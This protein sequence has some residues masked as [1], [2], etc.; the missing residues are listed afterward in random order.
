MRRNNN[1]LIFISGICLLQ[2][3][4]RQDPSMIRR[5]NLVS[6]LFAC[7]IIVIGVFL[8]GLVLTQAIRIDIASS[9]GRSS[10]IPMSLC[11]VTKLATLRL[12]GGWLTWLI[13][14]LLPGSLHF[15][16]YNVRLIRIMIIHAFCTVQIFFWFY[17]FW[18]L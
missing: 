16:F 17:Y 13:M 11:N 10:L 14:L 5:K 3:T 4:L 8:F 12:V 2:V 9:S 1:F 18:A 6:C 7:F 15:S